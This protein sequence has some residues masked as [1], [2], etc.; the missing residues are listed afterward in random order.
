M[1][2]LR[3]RKRRQTRDRR[4]RLRTRACV[5]Q[6]T[7]PLLELIERQPTLRNVLAQDGGDLISVGVADEQR[8]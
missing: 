4:R 5:E 8:L 3:V 2:V 1:K 7:E 6:K